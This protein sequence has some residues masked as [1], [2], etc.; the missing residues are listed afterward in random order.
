[1]TITTSSKHTYC[2]MNLI[3]Q[4][5]TLAIDMVEYVQ[6]AIRHFLEECNKRVTIPTAMY[7]FDVN[8]TQDRLDDEQKAIFH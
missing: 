7:L 6:E 2:G 8:P 3:F 4:D 5:K 1:M